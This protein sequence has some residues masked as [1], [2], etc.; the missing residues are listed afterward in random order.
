[1]LK[2]LVWQSVTPRGLLVE[3]GQVKLIFDHA[4]KLVAYS[5]ENGTAESMSMRLVR[6]E[7][8][9]HEMHLVFALSHDRIRSSARPAFTKEHYRQLLEKAG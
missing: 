8:I 2:K 6:R 3:V 5:D 9:G 1:M 7:D 4:G